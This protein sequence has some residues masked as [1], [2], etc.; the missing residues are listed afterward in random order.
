MSDEVMI[1]MHQ[2]REVITNP[3]ALP[4][5]D[6]ITKETSFTLILRMELLLGI[7]HRGLDLGC[8]RNFAS[9]ELHPML[10]GFR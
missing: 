1:S 7:R 5:H 9:F 8:N 10:G 4:Y 6:R 2:I 3:Q